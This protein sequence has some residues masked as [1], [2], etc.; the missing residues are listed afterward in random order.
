MLVS[1]VQSSNSTHLYITRRSSQ[2]HSFT[3]IT[4]FFPPHSH[5]TSSNYYS[6]NL[7]VSGVQALFQCLTKNDF[8]LRLR[9]KHR[10][11][12]QKFNVCDR[13]VSTGGFYFVVTGR[14]L[15]FSWRTP[16]NRV[17][18]YFSLSPFLCVCFPRKNQTASCLCLQTD[19]PG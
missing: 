18:T 11:A 12:N 7:S 4:S 3:R 5:L 8:P 2:V 9:M 15:L 10:K 14:V 1:G 19:S 13:D 17:F 6:F 16:N